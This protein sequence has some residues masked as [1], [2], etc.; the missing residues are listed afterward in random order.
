[1]NPSEAAHTQNGPRPLRKHVRALWHKFLS[2]RHHRREVQLYSQFIRPGD[3]CFDIGAN[4]GSRTSIF[5]SLKARVLAVE[6]QPGCA[7]QLKERFG[8]NA[9][10]KLEETAVGA[11]KG[12]VEMWIGSAS[13]LSSLSVDWI[14]AVKSSGRFSQQVWEKKHAVPMTTLDELIHTHGHPSFTKIDVEGYEFEVLKGLNHQLRSLSFEFTPECLNTAF[15]CLDRL[16]SIGPV[17]A[18]YSLGE[19]MQLESRSWISTKTLKDKLIG[20]MNNTR[21]FGDV[22]IRSTSRFTS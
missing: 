22:Y 12:E 11:T 3:L 14:G 19:S 13:A 18:N 4:V 6:P 20:F 1:M 17:E 10:F 7:R 21:V 15:A 16:D 2:Y 9:S 5:L 8:T